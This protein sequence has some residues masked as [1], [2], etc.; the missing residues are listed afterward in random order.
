MLPARI[1]LVEDEA[2][3]AEPV[4]EGLADEGFHVDVAPDGATAR[5]LLDR[6]WD[7][8]V[9]DLNLPDIPGESL[10]SYLRQQPAY[11]A[12][13]ILTARN[14]I[15]DKL[16]LFRQGCD[17]YLTKPF[18]FEELLVRVRALLR[19]GSHRPLASDF[20]Y[21]DIILDPEGHRLT[22]G[23]KEIS[24]TPKESAICRLLL[25]EP[26]RIVSR[27]EILQG[28]WGLKDEPDSNLIGVHMFHLKKKL[29]QLGRDSWLQTVRMA[30]FVLTKPAEH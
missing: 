14:N 1:L 28:V 27:R 13:L 21:E 12:V 4:R 8:I 30:G 2:D 24:L 29:G 25:T 16:A 9:L 17:D 5:R 3:L 22:A 15:Q 20:Q 10:L 11:P 19:R 18:V 26:G 23:E 7:L 6:P